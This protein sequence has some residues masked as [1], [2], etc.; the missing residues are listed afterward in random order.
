M[1]NISA[2][3]W[4]IEKQHDDESSELDRAS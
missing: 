3:I 4:F 2:R 1:C